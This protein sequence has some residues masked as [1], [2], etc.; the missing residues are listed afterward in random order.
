MWRLLLMEEMQRRSSRTKTQLNSKKPKMIKLSFNDAFT[1]C[2]S[3]E[4]L[5]SPVG[6]S[7]D[8]RDRVQISII[9]T[10]FHKQHIIN[11]YPWGSASTSDWL[12]HTVICNS[13]PEAADRPHPH[14]DCVTNT[15]KVKKRSL[16]KKRDKITWLWNLSHALM[17]LCGESWRPMRLPPS[18]HCAWNNISTQ[19][20]FQPEH[21]LRKLFGLCSDF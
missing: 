11:K 9:P 5:L 21:P 10:L 2:Q 14:Q 20:C 8:Q 1:S 4:A 6:Q 15:L 18:S 7:D 19:G 13:D 16:S 3:K 12:H 17:N